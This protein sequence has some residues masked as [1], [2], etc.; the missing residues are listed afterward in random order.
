MEDQLRSHGFTLVELIVVMAVLGILAAVLVPRSGNDAIIL[1]TQAEQFAADIRYLQSLAMTQGLSG[2]ASRRYR[3]NYT[4]TS[5]NFTDVSGVAVAHPSGTTGSIA[6]AGGV[7]ISPY[8][9]ATLPNNVVSFDAL[10]RPY[11]DAS[12]TTPLASTAT[13]S[14]ARSGSTRVVQIFPE[15]GM[16]RLP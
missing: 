12:A 10:G 8:P 7:S 1:S 9:A 3:I 11:T 6:F 14:L 16:V 5:Y 13:L 2:V 15:T 4:A